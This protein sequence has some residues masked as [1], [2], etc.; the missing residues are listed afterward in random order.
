MIDNFIAEK[1]D[2]FSVDTRASV[3][4]SEMLAIC[5]WLSAI[6]NSGFCRH[7]L[8]I[9]ENC[10]EIVSSEEWAEESAEE[11]DEWLKT[12]FVKNVFNYL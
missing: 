4:A 1:K 2:W 7:L 8:K 9:T 5:D 11:S 10:S 6:F 3:S 12:C